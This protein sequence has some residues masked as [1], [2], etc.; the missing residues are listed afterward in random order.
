MKIIMC[1]IDECICYY[2]GER[3]Y[4]QA[5][6]IK[7]NIDKINKLYEEGNKIIY[8]TSR[9]QTT[10]LNWYFLTEK[11]LKEWGC[12]YHELRLDK[13]HYDLI[14]DDKSKRIEEI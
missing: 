14:I 13:P 11:Q 8:W 3:I 1:D 9:G 10:G 2:N 12:K 6:P 5:I 4:E 7:E